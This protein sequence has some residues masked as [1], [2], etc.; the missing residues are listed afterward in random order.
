LLAVHFVR[1]TIEPQLQRVSDKY[2]PAGSDQ[3]EDLATLGS[4]QF[5][6]LNFGFATAWRKATTR[7]EWR[8]I[9]D[10]A[11]LQRSSALKEE[12]EDACM[13]VVYAV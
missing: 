7:D 12:K 11:T 10:T 9:V 3:Q 4:V 2:R 6:P 13:S 1:T 5:R 8:H